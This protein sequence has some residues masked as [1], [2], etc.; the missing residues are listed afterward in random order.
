MFIILI[1][2]HIFQKDTHILFHKLHQTV[3]NLIFIC[4]YMLY[5]SLK[6]YSNILGFQFSL[7]LHHDMYTCVFVKIFYYL[8]YF[9]FSILLVLVLLSLFLEIV[10]G[11]GT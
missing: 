5:L 9:L 1:L 6:M 8:F 10:H 2:Y 11:A 4:M 3:A 7:Q